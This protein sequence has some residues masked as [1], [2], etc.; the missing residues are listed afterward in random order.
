MMEQRSILH[1]LFLENI[2]SPFAIHIL[3]GYENTGALPE[4]VDSLFAQLPAATRTGP[5]GIKLSAKLDKQRKLGYGKIAPEFSQP[6][7]SGIPVA[8]SSFRG[9]YLL[10]DFWASWCRPCRDENPYVVNAFNKYKDK[11]FHVLSVSLDKQDGK[12]KWM[13]AIHDDQLYWT[14]VSDLQ[15]WNNAVAV[16]YSIEAIPRNFLLDRDGKIIGRD[17]RG[18]TLEKVLK[19]IYK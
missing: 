19:E 12:D 11:G 3:T 9:K 10:I 18:E 5:T 17:L 13:K 6:D 1:D 14:H 2:S 4:Q 15:Y 7:T 8:L 16:M